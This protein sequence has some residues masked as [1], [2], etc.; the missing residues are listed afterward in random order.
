MVP[1]DILTSLFGFEKF[2]GFWFCGMSCLLYTYY[3]YFLF[4]FLFVFSLAPLVLNKKPI[5]T[6]KNL[7]KVN[8]I[9]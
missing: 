2:I 5:K 4:V 3:D 7:I 6:Y 9:S 8:E 1:T